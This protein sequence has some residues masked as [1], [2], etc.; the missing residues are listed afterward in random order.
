MVYWGDLWCL[1][2]LIDAYD[3]FGKGILPSKEDLA[4]LSRR[5]QSFPTD[6]S[7]NPTGVDLKQ[8]D[9]LMGRQV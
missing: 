9:T 3:L 4:S 8:F 2:G 5:M 1:R 7:Y 6:G